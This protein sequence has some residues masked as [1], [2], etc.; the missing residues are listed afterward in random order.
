MG[1]DDFVALQS[2]YPKP[3]YLPSLA[4]NDP[5]VQA[6][7]NKCGAG[8]VLSFHL[9]DKRWNGNYIMRYATSDGD[10]FVK[11]NHEENK[12]VFVAEAVGLTSLL[13]SGAVR[14]PK[15]LHVGEIHGG[16]DG[17]GS[18]LITEFLELSPFGS[19]TT[20]NQRILGEQ[21]A[22]LHTSGNLDDIHKGRFGFMVNNFH[23]RTPLD[24]TWSSTWVEFFTRR[25]TSQLGML[26]KE[27]VSRSCYTRSCYM[28]SSDFNQTFVSLLSRVIDQLPHDFNKLAIT[29]SLLH[30]DLW[31]GNAG[32]T[33][34]GPVLFDPACFFG[35]SEFD[36]A[37]MKIFGGFSDEF[38]QAY[39]EILPQEEGFEQRE[40]YYLLYNYLNQLN[41]FGDEKV[42]V[43]CISVMQEILQG[44]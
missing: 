32:A 19:M 31:I 13:K 7:T 21:I 16:E 38:F 1:L 36:L 29:P 8:Q 41:L 33:T 4:A 34:D 17:R 25:L 3:K 23:S 43:K 11:L 9:L 22:R 18:F 26:Q 12:S 39:Y 35:H 5:I 40:R 42:L 6:I 2:E 10:L 44:D 24:N 28:M 27:Q 37:I 30:G 20:T 15:P 14:A